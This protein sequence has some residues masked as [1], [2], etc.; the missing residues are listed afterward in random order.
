[1]AG[2]LLPAAIAAKGF[3]DSSIPLHVTAIAAAN[4]YGVETTSL[5]SI[6]WHHVV[7]VRNLSDANCRKIYIDNSVAAEDNVGDNDSGHTLNNN[8][9]LTIGGDCPGQNTNNFNVPGYALPGTW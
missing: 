7:A 4:T 6:G 3:V 2:V 8:N 9:A 5:P 1:M